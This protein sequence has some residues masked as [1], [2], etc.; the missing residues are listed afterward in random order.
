MSVFI[1]QT[2]F[3]LA[4]GTEVE[5]SIQPS[6]VLSPPIAEPEAKKQFLK[7]L[8]ERMQQNPIPVDSPRF[9]RDMLHER[10]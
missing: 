7:R 9:T 10:R 3:D 8:I 4:E 1:P 2:A 5:L 6:K